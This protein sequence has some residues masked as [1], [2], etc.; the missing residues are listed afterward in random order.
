M[1]L[2][3][4]R[5]LGMI[6]NKEYFCIILKTVHYKWNSNRFEYTDINKCS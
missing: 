2:L 4:R 6:V 5:S 1:G 3:F